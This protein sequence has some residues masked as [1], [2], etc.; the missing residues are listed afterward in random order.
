M[1]MPNLI[2]VT[3]NGRNV[4]KTT[5]VEALIKLLCQRGSVYGLKVIRQDSSKGDSHGDHSNLFKSY[6]L[7]E[8][9]CHLAGL[10]YPCNLKI[11]EE[12]LQYP[13][14]DTA[15]MVKA[16]AKRAW[17]IEG[18]DVDLEHAVF[19]WSS[20]LESNSIVICESAILREFVRPKIMVA[21]KQSPPWD[22]LKE[23]KY[24]FNLADIVIEKGSEMPDY[25]LWAKK[26]V[27]LINL[28]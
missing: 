10:D 4:G 2:L 20:Q 18:N 12:T 6:C 17:I 13:N 24:P 26:V 27:E 8:K 19:T 3:G 16:G 11:E 7:D 21:I 1:D 22:N 15:R 5:L 14:K 23:W 9:P 28:R 25:N